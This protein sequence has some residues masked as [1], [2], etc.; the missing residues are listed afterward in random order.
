[1]SFWAGLL[2]G[3]F[4]SGIG[5]YFILLWIFKDVFR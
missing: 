5:F 4:V 2:V 3:L 1:M